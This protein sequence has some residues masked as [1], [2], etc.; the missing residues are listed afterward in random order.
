MKH[1]NHEINLHY[2]TETNGIESKTT[3]FDA[4][5]KFV[6]CFRRSQPSTVKLTSSAMLSTLSGAESLHRSG[7]GVFINKAGQ[8]LTDLHVVDGFNEIDVQT[9]QGKHYSAYVDRVDRERGLA[10]LSIAI[11]KNSILPHLDLAKKPAHNSAAFVFGYPAGK[12]ELY[13]SPSRFL[14]DSSFEQLSFSRMVNISKSLVPDQERSVMVLESHTAPGE[15]G[16]PV[17]DMDGQIIGLVQASDNFSTSV[18]T[19]WE[20]IKS[21]LDFKPKRRSTAVHQVLDHL[22]G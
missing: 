19:T 2:L 14:M 11:S 17:I 16:A 6:D 7:S 8:V 3:A 21:F 9:S 12:T 20:D 4:H 5:E 15:S 13:G 10:L 18:A 22:H 1:S